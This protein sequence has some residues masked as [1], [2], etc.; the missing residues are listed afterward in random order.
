MTDNSDLMQAALL[1]EIEGLTPE[2]I[3]KLIYKS[4][5][6]AYNKGYV[7]GYITGYDDNSDK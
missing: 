6:D 4:K 2:Q 1:T 5:N 7:L 3:L